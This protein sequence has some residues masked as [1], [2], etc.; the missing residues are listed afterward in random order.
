MYLLSNTRRRN[1]LL[2]I[3]NLK[4]ADRL[5]FLL[6]KYDKKNPRFVLIKSIIYSVCT[7]RNCKNNLK[8]FVKRYIDS[9]S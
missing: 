6:K 8:A 2:S 7:L 3:L 1:K 9:L 5:S 4:E